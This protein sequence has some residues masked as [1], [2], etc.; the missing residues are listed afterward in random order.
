MTQE[1]KFTLMS[2]FKGRG[3]IFPKFFFLME[4]QGFIDTTD[5]IM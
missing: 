2:S 5:F 3:Q 1:F 4:F